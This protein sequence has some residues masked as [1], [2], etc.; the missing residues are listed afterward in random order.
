MIE[1]S[2]R[3]SAYHIASFSEFKSLHSNTSYNYAAVR[4]VRTLDA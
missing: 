1:Y 2:R 4:A 3:G